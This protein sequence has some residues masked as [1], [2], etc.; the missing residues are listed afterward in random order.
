MIKDLFALQ[1]INVLKIANKR[2]Y[3]NWDI[4]ETSNIIIEYLNEFVDKKQ[5][6]ERLLKQKQML[7]NEIKR[8]ENILSNKNFI[9]KASK[10]KVQLEKDK[11]QQYKKQYEIVC[12]SI[13]KV[14]K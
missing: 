13:K 8:S 14:S 12:V 9:A 3:D 2:I 10:E 5:E 1:N 6:I 11:Y 4:I 7:E